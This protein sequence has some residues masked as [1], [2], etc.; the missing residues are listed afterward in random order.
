MASETLD[1]VG[2]R[3]EISRCQRSAPV[4]YIVAYGA[5][6]GTE[7]PG[8]RCAGRPIHMMSRELELVAG[9]LCDLALLRRERESVVVVSPAAPKAS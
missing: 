8:A 3:Y 2:N 1:R 4:F 9:R 7:A 6:I 5:T